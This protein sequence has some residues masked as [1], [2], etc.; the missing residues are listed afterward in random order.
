M[1]MLMSL[2]SVSLYCELG[3]RVS[4]TFEEINRSLDRMKWYLFPVK[5]WHMLPIVIVAA[6]EPITFS[7]FGTVS[8]SRE[9]L[10]TVRIQKLLILCCYFFFNGF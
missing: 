6:Q 5:I 2:G 9:D 1:Q 8:C 7:V 4:N 10:K 3:H